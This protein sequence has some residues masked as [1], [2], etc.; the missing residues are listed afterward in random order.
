MSMWTI[1][2]HTKGMLYLKL[3]TALHSES[4]EPIEVYR[5]LYDNDMAPLWA[6][7][8][9]MFH[10]EV[11]PGQKRFTEVARVR[12]MM[13]EDEAG[14]LTF[15]HDAWGD[16]KS[17]EEF[18]AAYS[19]DRNHLRGTRYLLESP[20]GE[21]I[22]NLNTLRFARGLVGIA[23]ISINPLQRARGYASMLTR[24]V[25]ELL[26][27]E[28]AAVRFMLYSEVNPAIYERL[29]FVRAPDELQFHLPS[30]AMI[31]GDAPITEREVGFL[32]EY[33]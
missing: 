26:R 1:Y 10:E 6:R 15:G 8:K 12:T 11:V 25:M 16:G 7:P 29:G 32:R 28:D 3:G 9:Q 13:P 21:P 14:Y 17:V 27:S 23:S 33:F 30:I 5:T 20:T 24:A 19:S 18:V 31:T 4:C 2:K 22:G